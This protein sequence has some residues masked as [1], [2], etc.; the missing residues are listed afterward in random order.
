[1]SDSNLA[2]SISLHS[3]S[4]FSMFLCRVLMPLIAVFRP[5]CK[6]AFSELNYKRVPNRD[7]EP[8]QQTQNTKDS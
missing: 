1:M 6:I 3:A 5:G 4:F 8:L 2:S 7:L